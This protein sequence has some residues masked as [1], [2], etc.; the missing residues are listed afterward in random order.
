MAGLVREMQHLTRVP[1]GIVPQEGAIL[2]EIQCNH[3]YFWT[4]TGPLP[5]SYMGPASSGEAGIGSVTSIEQPLHSGEFKVA[6][7][8]RP[9]EGTSPTSLVHPSGVC[10]CM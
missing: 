4:T 3:C 6:V 2:S 5:P 7:V 10:V 8:A 9:Y 1:G